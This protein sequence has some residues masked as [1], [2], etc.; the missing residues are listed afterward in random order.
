MGKGILLHY[1][2][3]KHCFKDAAIYRQ[4]VWG[5]VKQSEQEY[6]YLE[7]IFDLNRL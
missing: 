5:E 2:F 6:L 4:G 1:I 3:G 7:T